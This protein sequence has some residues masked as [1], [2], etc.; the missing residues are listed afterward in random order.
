MN[1]QNEFDNINPGDSLNLTPGEY[2]G[3][4]KI[5]KPCIIQ[6]KNCVIWG[7]NGPIVEI[8]SKGVTLKDIQLEITSNENELD[9]IALLVHRGM[10]PVI[11]NVGIVGKVVGIQKEEDT[12]D[13]PKTFNLGSL[14]PNCKYEK[15]LRIISPIECKIKSDISSITIKTE[16]INRGFNDILLLIEPL[17][18]NTIISGKLYLISRF[19]RRINIYG[20]VSDNLAISEDR[21][22]SDDW[23]ELIEGQRYELSTTTNNAFIGV[24]WHSNEFIKYQIQISGVT[25]ENLNKNKEGDISSL[26]K[27]G[28]IT[29]NKQNYI[30]KAVLCFNL[31]EIEK[32]CEK[33][34]VVLKID[35]IVGGIN[36]F[37]QIDKLYIR[38]I[39]S[40]SENETF[41]Y[42]MDQFS[43]LDN[44]IT[45]FEIYKYK[46]NW[47]INP[48]GRSFR[49]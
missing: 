27:K 39:S 29:Q 5:T 43:P 6:G 45:L 47:K 14:T 9:S 13:F 18:P 25:N 32:A 41:F 28:D 31:S 38:G 42:K 1:I 37:S 33:I 30:D 48:I 7:Q 36:N 46:K 21:K 19:T 44:A 34:K 11:E 4:L 22:K 23:I 10:N 24:G 20:M 17:P 3:P 49:Q 35:P 15:E 8:L 2:K 40:K 26:L 16:K 12:W